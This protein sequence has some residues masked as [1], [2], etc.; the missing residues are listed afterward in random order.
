MLKEPAARP[1]KIIIAV[2]VC[3]PGS[4]QKFEGIV[5]RFICLATPEHFWAVSQFYFNFA[6]VSDEEVVALL[7][8]RSTA[9][10]HFERRKQGN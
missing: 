1:K 3:S 9:S 4:A 8:Q 2:P 6:Q 10:S 7:S 5:D